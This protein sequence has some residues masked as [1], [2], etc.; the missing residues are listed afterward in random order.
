MSFLQMFWAKPNV[1]ELQ[2]KRDVKGLAKALR[3][4]KDASVRRSAAHAL[5]YLGDPAGVEPLIEALSDDHMFVRSDAAGSLAMIGIPALDALILAIQGIRRGD[6]V[7]N[8]ILSMRMRG[9]AE[10]ALVRIGAPAVEPLLGVL[11]DNYG[12][13]NQNVAN[14]LARIGDRRAIEPLIALLRNNSDSKRW[15]AARTLGEMKAASAVQP[16][17]AALQDNFKFVRKYAAVALGQIGDTR[18]IGPLS[19]LLS[20][21][22]EDVRSEAQAALASLK[23][24]AG[25]APA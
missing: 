16:L 3:Y 15:V 7:R 13:L 10:S 6:L 1:E 25:G 24:S 8:I 4:K 14:A 22:D 12:S 20:D 19:T 17:I 23:R 9:Q 18:A 2:S 5:G 21:S 11:E